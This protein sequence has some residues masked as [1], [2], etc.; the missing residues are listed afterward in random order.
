MNKVKHYFEE[1]KETLT[2]FDTELENLQT[3]LEYGKELEP[4]PEEFM[5]PNN[6]VPACVSNAFIHAGKDKDGKIHFEGYSDA[7]VVRGYIAILVKG[8]SG[9]YPDEIMEA[10]PYVEKFT[11]ESNIK[12][13]LTPSRANA[14]GNI[15]EMMLKKTEELR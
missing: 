9:L 6:K 11:E 4:Y 13:S 14:F 10:K 12:A 8:L 7:L 2:I 15:F 3:L 5:T 1:M